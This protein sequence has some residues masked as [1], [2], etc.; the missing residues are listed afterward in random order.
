VLC[1]VVPTNRTILLWDELTRRT[2]QAEGTPVVLLRDE[3][4]LKIAQVDGNRTLVLTSWS[5]LLG[6]VRTA[7]EAEDNLALIADLR[8]LVGLAARMDTSGFVPFTLSDLTAPAPRRARAREPPIRPVPMTARRSMITGCAVMGY[9]DRGYD[10][11]IFRNW[12][13]SFSSSSATATSGSLAWP[14]RSRKKMYS[15][16]FFL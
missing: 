11:R 6:Q 16:A 15:Q 13:H 9:I 12:Q 10:P 4:E 5:F 1:F 8:Q 14:N 2:E 3:P 7:L